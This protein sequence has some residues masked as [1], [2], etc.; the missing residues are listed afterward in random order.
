MIRRVIAIL[1]TITPVIGQAAMA[2]DRKLVRGLDTYI[3]ATDAGQV[4]V[5]CDPDRVH[6]T[7]P[8]GIIVV[9]MPK[10]RNANRV[11]LLAETGEQAAFDLK[12]GVA[13]QAMSDPDAWN[14]MSRMMREGGRIAVVTARDAFTLDLSPL[15]SL[16]CS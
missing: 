4:T 2:W 8:Q 3:A 11:V 1:A 12:D 13:A 7:T 10:D 5:V 6:G 16:R 9:L 15:P 14:E